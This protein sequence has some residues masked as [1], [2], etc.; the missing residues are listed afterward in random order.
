MRDYCLTVP[1]ATPLLNQI[2]KMHYQKYKR[3]REEWSWL[4]KAAAMKAGIKSGDTPINRCI[5]MV[6][7]Y[8]WHNAG[9]LPDWD[10]LYAGLKPAI[11]CLSVASKSSP[12]G[13]GIIVDDSPKHIISLTATPF[14]CKRDEVRTE[15]RIME[16]GE[17]DGG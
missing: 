11:D 1:K 2:R 9:T 17:P 10:G 13:L 14:L 5:V 16:V 12:S 15:I 4:I 7:R 8:Q 3:L 6:S